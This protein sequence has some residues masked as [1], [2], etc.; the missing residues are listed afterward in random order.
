MKIFLD[1]WWFFRLEKK[2]YIIGIVMLITVT[3]LE[4]FVPYVIRIIVDHGT[5]KTLTAGILLKWTLLVF[6]SG[7]L[8]Y[9]CRYVWRVQLFGAAHR[10]GQLLRDRF[11]QHLT[12]QSPTFYQRHRIGK[13]MAHGTNDIQAVTYTA[14]DGVMVI[15]D[16]L[17]GGIMIIS[18]MVFFIDWK[19]TLLAMLPMPIMAWTA[20]YYGKLLHHRFKKAQEAF[21]DMTEDVQQNISSVR[22]IKAFGKQDSELSQFKKRMNQIVS[23][24]LSAA[25]ID[26]LYDPTIFIITGVSFL[27]SIGFGSW[28][29]LQGKITIGQLTQFTFYIGD[30]I[31]PMLALGWL[32]NIIERGRAS[33]GRL[34]KLL[35][36]EEPIIQVSQPIKQL[37]SGEVKI[38]I[39]RFT[40]P[41]SNLVALQKLD[42][43]IFPRQTIGLVGRTGS[44]KTTLLRLLLRE[45]ELTEGQIRLSEID[46]RHIALKTL[47]VAFGYVPQEHMLFSTTIA[48][49]IAFGYP[50]ATPEEIEQAARDAQVH[51]DI[52]QFAQGYQTVVGERGVTLSGGQKQRISIARAILLK[53]EI[54][55]LD[56]A[57][58]AVDAKTEQQIIQ[59]IRQKRQ[60]QTTII[61]AHRLSAVEHADQIWV[62]E[63]GEV[64]DSGTHRE[65]AKKSGWYQQTLL[66]QQTLTEGLEGRR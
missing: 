9:G 52:L 54:L 35:Q 15:V 3:L 42:L 28:F 16:G 38:Y 7:I 46:H 18:T 5:A 25:R 50:A 57:L 61:V 30:L 63:Q 8:V 36:D 51:D 41:N 26:A 1:L 44:G 48:E 20:S 66:R 56:D 62:F 11:Y 2:R 17:I 64:I 53:P 12:K 49:N 22:M 23:T 58:S 24:N 45:F 14:G 32:F 10:L 33:Y 55:I 13:L 34:Q 43:N 19:L 6:I 27:I 47:R 21:E 31:W 4:L 65:L 37:P 59:M 29:V 60:D 39:P 40:Y